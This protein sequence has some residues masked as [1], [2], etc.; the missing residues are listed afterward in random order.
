MITYINESNQI[1]TEEE[2]L[3]EKAKED[4]AVSKEEKLAKKLKKAERLKIFK[5][6]KS[7]MKDFCN[8]KHKENKALP[9]D[10][11]RALSNEEKAIGDIVFVAKHKL[12]FLNGKSNKIFFNVCSKGAI[13]ATAIGAAAG[14]VVISRKSNLNANAIK[15]FKDELTEYLKKESK[16][17]CS[18]KINNS[19]ATVIVTVNNI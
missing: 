14:Y 4:Q 9:K 11:K 18:L 16:Y 17:D 5:E 15:V 10:E 2:F 7:T 6:I 3:L 12:D 8:K 19:P 1:C 13:A